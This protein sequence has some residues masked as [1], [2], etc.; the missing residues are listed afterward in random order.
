MIDDGTYKVEGTFEVTFHD[1]EI[2]K[3]WL[4]NTDPEI[5][6][7]GLPAPK[8]LADLIRAEMAKDDD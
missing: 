3:K 6:L 1:P 8:W 7:N 2:I 4:E 5:T